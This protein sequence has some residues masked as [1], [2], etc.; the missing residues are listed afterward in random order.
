MLKF[1]VQKTVAALSLLLGVLM[2]VSC[3]SNR[4][5]RRELL[6]L[7]GNLDTAGN[8]VV[9][10]EEPKIQ[11]GDMLAITVYSDDPEAT[12]IY[13][14]AQISA[15]STV[16][17]PGYLVD[18]QGNIRFQG[19]G[20]LKVEGLTKLELMRR[21]DDSLKRFLM[22]PYTDI[23]F[24]NFK[25]NIIGEVAKPGPVTIPEGRL[26]ILELVGLAGDLTV[27]GRRDNVLVIREVD[28]K[29]QFGRVNLRDPGIFQS[30]YFYLQQN[31]VVFVEA[32]KRKPSGNEQAVTRNIQIA[33][34]LAGLV[35]TII[36]IY[37]L[38][39]NN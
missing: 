19:L 24:L 28:G 11:I 6:Y 2:L 10:Y 3:E 26:S 18:Q 13:N 9:R 8:E 4:K 5:L 14:Q 33:G 29:R 34:M 15:G 20:S 39:K 37:T 1:K 38:L 35:S 31:D 7:Q 17:S 25:V 12:T 23:R 21:M 32:N 16:S 30:P 36:V 27:Y 22:N